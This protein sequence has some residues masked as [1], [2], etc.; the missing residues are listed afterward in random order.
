MD[1]TQHYSSDNEIDIVV[2]VD[3]DLDEQ[4]KQRVEYAMLK[5]SGVL[6]AYFDKFRQHLLI[7][8]YNPA[9]I[10][11]SK[12]LKLVKQ[13]HLNAELVFGI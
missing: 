13:Q 10:N 8:G 4:N 9:Q 7:I 11:S 5:A 6:R 2:H 3:E 12:I 1:I